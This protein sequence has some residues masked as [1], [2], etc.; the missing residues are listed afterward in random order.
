MKLDLDRYV[1]GMLLWLSNKTSASASKIYKAKFG[2][3]ISEWRVLSFVA[4]YPWSTATQASEFMGSDKAAVSRSISVLIGGNWLKSR[5][6]GLRKVEYATTV[7]GQ[8]LYEN[9]VKVAIAREN[10]LLQGFSPAERSLLVEFLHRLLKN[11]DSAGS[12]GWDED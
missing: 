2:I 1:P 12:V 9:I 11:L 8:R 6:V 10:A 4:L 3:G 5:P 7:S